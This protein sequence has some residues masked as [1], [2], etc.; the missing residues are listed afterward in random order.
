MTQDTVRYKPLTTGFYV[1]PRL[2]AG[3]VTLYISPHK[4]T[5][6]RGH[7]G[8]IN[9]QQ[10]QTTLRG[11]LGEWLIIGGSGLNKTHEGTGYTYRTEERGGQ[12]EQ[13]IVKVEEI[14]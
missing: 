2:S 5:Q 6:S 10:A 7:G 8:I 3:Q 1:A 4:F 11:P 14:H 13:I 12:Q 9:L